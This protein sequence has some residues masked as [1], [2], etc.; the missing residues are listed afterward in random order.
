MIMREREEREERGKI[1]VTAGGLNYL[2]THV[3][4]LNNRRH[5]HVTKTDVAARCPCIFLPFLD[6]GGDH[7]QLK[8]FQFPVHS[9]FP[10]EHFL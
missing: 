4:G 2:M 3:S 10:I 9:S 1:L 8:F 7:R 6:G 5:Q